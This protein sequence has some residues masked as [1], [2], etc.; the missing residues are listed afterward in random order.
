[1]LYTI[2]GTTPSIHTPTLPLQQLSQASILLNPNAAS[3]KLFGHSGMDTTSG[4]IQMS[5]MGL[6]SN[7]IDRLQVIYRQNQQCNTSSGFRSTTKDL[8]QRGGFAGGAGIGA[9]DGRGDERHGSPGPAAGARQGVQTAPGGPGGGLPAKQRV[10]AGGPTVQ[11]NEDGESGRAVEDARGGGWGDSGESGGQRLSDGS[12]GDDDYSQ[13]LK[14]KAAQALFRM[15]LEPGGEVSGASRRI[16]RTAMVEHQHAHSKKLRL[17]GVICLIAVAL[18]KQEALP[19]RGS[20]HVNPTTMHRM[21]ARCKNVCESVDD[22]GDDIHNLQLWYDIMSAFRWKLLLLRPNKTRLDFRTKVR[23]LTS[24]Y[25]PGEPFGEGKLLGPIQRD[26]NT[27]ATN[28]FGVKHVIVL[29]IDATQY[30]HT[31]T[32]RHGGTSQMKLV[33]DGVVVALM[34][35]INVE[36]VVVYRLVSGCMANLTT[37]RDVTWE[38]LQADGHQVGVDTQRPRLLLIKSRGEWKQLSKCK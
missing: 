19:V 27:Y 16:E 32:C 4:M 11:R 26:Y 18:C 34:K 23:G 36:S 8:G 31:T 38:L 2:A 10:S 9:A 13:M 12:I 5:R 3:R 35:L 37:T 6:S 1:M 29:F 33:R 22:R 28:V 25:A 7:S 17:C 24:V 14:I 30:A 21:L 15:S 20:T